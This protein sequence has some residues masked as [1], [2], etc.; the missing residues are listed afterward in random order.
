MFSKHNNKL[1][2][3][4]I[5]YFKNIAVCYIFIYPPSLMITLAYRKRSFLCSLMN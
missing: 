5:K 3:F 2:F 1:V 4:L